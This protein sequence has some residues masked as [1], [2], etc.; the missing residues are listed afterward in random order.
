MSRLPSVLALN[1]YSPGTKL[2]CQQYKKYSLKTPFYYE[3][4]VSMMMKAQFFNF[5]GLQ[6]FCSRERVTRPFLLL[7]RVWI[8]RLP[9]TLGLIIR[10]TTTCITV[11]GVACISS[12]HIHECRERTVMS[13]RN[14]TEA[15]IPGASLCGQN[16]YIYI[17]IYI[18]I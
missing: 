3:S 9:P 13:Q 17:Y 7:Q 1:L 14:H 4:H 5:I 11:W 8:A 15:D 10:K 18:Y 12:M 6:D 16:I 2:R